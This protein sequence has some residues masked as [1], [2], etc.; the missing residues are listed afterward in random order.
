MSLNVAPSVPRSLVV[1]TAIHT[2]DGE[3]KAGELDGTFH[4]MTHGIPVPGPG[5][6]TKEAP[7]AGER[8]DGTSCSGVAAIATVA[9]HANPRITAAARASRE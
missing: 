9:A 6:A 7:L 4:V 2:D 5:R 8:L 3:A 1:E